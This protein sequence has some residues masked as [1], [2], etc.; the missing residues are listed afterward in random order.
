ME[1][2]DRGRAS[3][4]GMAAADEFDTALDTNPPPESMTARREE[5]PQL[6][7]IERQRLKLTAQAAAQRRR[8]G[9]HGELRPRRS[10][11]P[12]ALLLLLL[13]VGIG[14]T[15]VYTDIEQPLLERITERVPALTAPPPHTE[16]YDDNVK[17]GPSPIISESDTTQIPA[18]PQ[19]SPEPAP[20]LPPNASG[21]VVRDTV[22]PESIAAP[23]DTTATLTATP[24]TRDGL[25][26]PMEYISL[27]DEP[28][29]FRQLVL[30]YRA[31]LAAAL[32][33]SSTSDT[34]V[35]AAALHQLRARALA[36]LGDAIEAGSLSTAQ[37]LS[38]EIDRIFPELVVDSEYEA[39]QTQAAAPTSTTRT[40]SAAATNA[41]NTEEANTPV[42]NEPSAPPPRPQIVSLSMVSGVVTND[43]FEPRNNGGVLLVN[44]GYRNFSYS[45][46]GGGPN[47]LLLRIRAPGNPLMLVEEPVEIFGDRGTK[48]F[49]VDTL[50]KENTIDH[51]QVDIVLHGRVI[52][53]RIVARAPPVY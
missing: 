10:R 52:E 1:P 14:V 7:A 48:S 3:D 18:E 53:S 33:D 50:L 51:Y 42:A 25:T 31:K 38:G 5:P 39:P 13:A 15:I 45:L 32:E 47:T 24:P 35:V 20:A 22:D 46:T 11:F 34:L 8:A 19:S 12:L 43:L 44:L 29:L 49:Q 40:T 27:R 36:E 41:A 16:T 6:T 2:H 28:D 37:K 26:L 23:A 30:F 9:G 21:Q 17:P 4:R